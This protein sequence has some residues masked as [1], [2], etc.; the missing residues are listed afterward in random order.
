MTASPAAFVPE[1]EDMT[2]YLQ[3]LAALSC[4]TQRACVFA[5]AVGI[6]LLYFAKES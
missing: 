5:V 2:L 3:E 6:A 1:V 4:A